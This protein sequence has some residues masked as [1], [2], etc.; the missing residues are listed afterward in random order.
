MNGHRKT[1]LY[2]KR[3][4]YESFKEKHKDKKKQVIY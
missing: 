4:V 1:K 2:Q 3:K